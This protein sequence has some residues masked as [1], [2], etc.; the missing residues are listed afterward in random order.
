MR[1]KGNKMEEEV[2]KKRFGM[3][4]E[5]AFII[6]SVFALWPGILGWEGIVWQVLKYAAVAGLIWI[7][8]RRVNRYRQRSEEGE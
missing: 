7:L 3:A 6:L 5:D 4:V 2:P 8:V 1:L